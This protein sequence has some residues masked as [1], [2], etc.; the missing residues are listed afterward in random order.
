MRIG[1]INC[2]GT[3]RSYKCKAKDMYCSSLFKKAFAWL[4]QNCDKV[5]IMS[6]KHGLLDPEKII[7]PYNVS[8]YGMTRSQRIRWSK[9]LYLQ[10]RECTDIQHDIFIVEGGVKYT[11]FI[12]KAIPHWHI[13]YERD[14]C[15]N[16][17]TGRRMQWYDKYLK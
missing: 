3:K 16:F 9:N 7:E 4:T 14:L 2:V 5:Y 10:L 8:L 1:L 12:Q 11:E 6:A 13:P 17:G 15:H